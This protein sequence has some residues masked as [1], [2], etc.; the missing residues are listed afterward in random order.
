MEDDDDTSCCMH[1]STTDEESTKRKRHL[2]WPPGRDWFARTAHLLSR[3]LQDWEH[4]FRARNT[5]TPAQALSGHRS[6]EI[7]V[8]ESTRM[9]VSP[10]DVAEAVL[11]SI[12]CCVAAVGV[13]TGQD[14]CVAPLPPS[15]SHPPV[16]TASGTPC[17]PAREPGGGGQMGNKDLCPESTSKTDEAATLLGLPAAHAF[18]CI[19]E[20][21]SIAAGLEALGEALYQ[22]CCSL[23]VNLSR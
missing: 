2:G 23:L 7:Q 1:P 20:V 5:S 4:A 17:A 6:P 14:L 13:S 9:D 18:R 3:I 21:V 19:G 8:P 22:R 16:S 12:H 10:E 11:N 15:P